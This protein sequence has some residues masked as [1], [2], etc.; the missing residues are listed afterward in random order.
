MVPVNNGFPEASWNQHLMEGKP[1]VPRKVA[2]DMTC[3]NHRS[4]NKIN[5]RHAS[6]FIL[7]TVLVYQNDSKTR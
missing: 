5:Q 4:V 1:F 6:G 7:D 2:M 3:H